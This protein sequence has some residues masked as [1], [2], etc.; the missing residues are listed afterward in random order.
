MLRTP[1]FNSFSSIIS[2]SPTLLPYE[3][4]FALRYI[5]RH[6]AKK[7]G[8]GGDGGGRPSQMANIKNKKRKE[9]KETI[10]PPDVPPPPPTTHAALVT[11]ATVLSANILSLIPPLPPKKKKKSWPCR[12]ISPQVSNKIILNRSG[13]SWNTSLASIFSLRDPLGEK[14]WHHYES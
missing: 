10:L 14:E 3:T 5:S 13:G 7:G 6:V 11:C 4:Y 2:L 12:Y 9:E 1:S 8:G